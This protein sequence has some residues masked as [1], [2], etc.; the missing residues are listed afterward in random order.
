MEKSPIGKTAQRM[1]MEEYGG[2][3]L[4]VFPS[5]FNLCNSKSI[6]GLKK[7]GVLVVSIFF[8]KYPCFIYL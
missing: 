1:P 8:K 2:W 6:T 3:V 5:Y 7:P 4:Y